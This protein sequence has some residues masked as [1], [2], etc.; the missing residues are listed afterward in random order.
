LARIILILQRT[1]PSENLAKYCNIAT[2]R[3]RQIWVWRHQKCRLQT[4]TDWRTFNKS[5]SKGEKRDTASH[6]L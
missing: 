5:F 3:W 1:K 4:K 2:W 6:L